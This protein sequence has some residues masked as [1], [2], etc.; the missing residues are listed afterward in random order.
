MTVGWQGQFFS[1]DVFIL[2]RQQ[3]NGIGID[4]AIIIDAL[5][6]AQWSDVWGE[7]KIKWV[8]HG[9]GG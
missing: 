9:V 1:H 4:E 2:F 3:Y 7:G 6:D 5:I 8:D